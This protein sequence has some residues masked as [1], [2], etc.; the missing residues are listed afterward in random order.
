MDEL[1]KV[2][3]TN[4]EKVLYPGLGLKKSQIIEYYIRIAPRMLGFLKNRAIVMNRY[5]DGIDKEGFY[6]KDA[7]VG[8]PTW[9][10]TFNN[11][12][13]K[14]QRE[15]NYI[16]CNSLDTLIWMANMAVLEINITLSTIDNYDTPDLVFF[17]I[18]P[19]PPYSFD[20]VI[21]IALLLKEKLDELNF[22]SFVKTSGK[23]GLHV[24]LP[25]IKSYNFK[26]T[27][28]FVHQ[29][30]K[31]LARESDLVV[32]EFR[33]SRDPGTIFIDYLQNTRGKTMIAPYSLRSEPGAS[34][35][36]PLEWKEL[37]K[38]LRPEEFNIFTI[39]KR[40]SDPWE[41]LLENKQELEM[42]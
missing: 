32:S 6:E 25:I 27:K 3:F 1:T 40:K 37:K 26:Q 8:I 4:L 33:N 17:D 7:P 42:K 15:I 22:I 29:F 13:E 36:T 39:I 19:E 23:K 20:D 10:E 28:E 16:V 31:F 12:S 24:V 21:D 41:G 34:I 11:Y 35:S 38:G 14:A 18:D 30:G 2:S 5:P 9:M